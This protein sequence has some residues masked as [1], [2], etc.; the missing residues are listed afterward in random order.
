MTNTGDSFPTTSNDSDEIVWSAVVRVTVY[1]LCP[2]M[3]SA[4]S[5][6]CAPIRSPKNCRISSMFMTSNMQVLCTVQY[7]TVQNSK[8]PRK[9][10]SP[11]TR[12]HAT[13]AHAHLLFSLHL[14]LSSHL[15]LVQFVATMKV[16]ELTPNQ[17]TAI[18][19]AR[20]QHVTIRKTMKAT[21]FTEGQVR[22]TFK[23]WDTSKSVESEPRS[24]RPSM[25]DG[26]IKRQ[27]RRANARVS[28]AV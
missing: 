22:A 16:K 3:V 21:G 6:T 4:D 12:I 9:V 7:C 19:I 28:G 24:G 25:T 18:L 14:R 10:E 27:T 8:R 26:R 5:Q 23:K 13:L 17:R 2:L 20:T 15:W 11:L 1:I